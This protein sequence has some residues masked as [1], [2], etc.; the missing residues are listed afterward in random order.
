MFS[1]VEW[2]VLKN[3][4]HTALFLSLYEWM[5]KRV[6]WKDIETAENME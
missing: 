6:S 5:M 1:G 3:G 4:G 2:R